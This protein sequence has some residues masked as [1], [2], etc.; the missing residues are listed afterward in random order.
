MNEGLNH[1]NGREINMIAQQL[2]EALSRSDEY[3]IQA[4]AYGAEGAAGAVCAGK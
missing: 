2:S 3:N 4:E 1:G